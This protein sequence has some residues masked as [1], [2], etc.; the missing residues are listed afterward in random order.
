MLSII[1]V[2]AY[3]SLFIIGKENIFLSFYMK[4]IMY[5]FFCHICFVIICVISLV[6]MIIC[7]SFAIDYYNNTCKTCVNT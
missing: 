2:C 3:I 7:D 5:S 4:K 6:F 1:Y